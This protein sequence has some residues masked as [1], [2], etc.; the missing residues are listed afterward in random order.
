MMK[1]HRLAAGGKRMACSL[2]KRFCKGPLREDTARNQID[3]SPNYC[4]G[5]NR[6]FNKRAALAHRERVPAP[7]AFRRLSAPVRAYRSSPA[8]L[9]IEIVPSFS[10]NATRMS[11]MLEQPSRR[12]A[13]ISSEIDTCS[14]AMTSWY[15]W[16]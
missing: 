8:R 4:T 2:R 5:S 13:S 12:M 10:S 9:I 1:A 11:A 7:E 14:R 6:S 16:P 3:H 15:R